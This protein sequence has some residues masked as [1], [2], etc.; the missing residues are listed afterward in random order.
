MKKNINIELFEELNNVE[1]NRLYE[2]S[3]IK[4]YSKGNI[5]FYEG[6]KPEKLHL[7][8]DGIIKVYKVDPKGNE[9]SYTL[10][11]TSNTNSRNCSYAKNKL[12]SYS[13]M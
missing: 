7:L 1:N 3:Q 5:V 6:D 2:I 8:L 10:L 13:N 4:N 11:S 9:N 12:S